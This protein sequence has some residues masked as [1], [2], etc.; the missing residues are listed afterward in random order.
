MMIV[1]RR[2]IAAL[3]SAG[4]LCGLLTGCASEEQKA[5]QVAQQQ[6]QLDGY[7]AKAEGWGE[8]ILAQIPKS[9]VEDAGP[10]A[11]GTRA[12]NMNYEEWPKYYIWDTIVRLK[13]TGAR[14][15]T[16]AA[17]ELDPWLKDQGWKRH[18]ER[19]DTPNQE[20]FTR[21][22]SRAQ[23][24]LMVEAYTQA[25]PR[26]QNIFFTIVTPPTSPAK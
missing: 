14:T 23:Y 16:E 25:P 24:T 8:E 15:P 1:R 21:Y 11:S 22:Y 13:P 26:A 2:A 10:A 12:A 4:A 3:L 5:A 19:E 9:E 17:D 18:E 6:E 7:I 20:S